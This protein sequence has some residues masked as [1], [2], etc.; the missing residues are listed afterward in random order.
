VSDPEPRIGVPFGDLRREL[1]ECG[2]DLH[3]AAARVIDSG[4]FVLGHELEAFEAEF[5]AYLADDA[6]VV[7]VGS[8]TEAIHLALVDA[9]VGPGDYVITVPNTAVPTVSAISAAGAIPLFADIDPT[10]FTMDPVQLRE[11]VSREKARLGSKLKAVVPVHLYG[12]TAD[13]DSILETAREFELT[14]VEDAAQAAGAQYKGRKAGTIG[15]YG[16]FS[17]YPSKN[18]G[19][20]GDGGAVVVRTAD[21]AARLRMLRNYGQER[22]YHHA[23]KGFN[24]RLDEIQAAILRAKLPRLDAWNRR[25][26]EIAAAYDA[27]ITSAR[28]SKPRAA[29]YG[30]H[31]WHLYVVR[32][33]DR[34]GLMAHL[35]VRGVG[36]L[37]HYPIPVHLQSAY[38][39]LGLERGAFPVAESAAS[40]ILSL[41]MFPQL[42]DEDVAYVSRCVSEYAG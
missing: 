19:C 18:L 14:V 9:G 26:C 28:I 5:A 33:P 24:S 15:D 34:D 4:W 20:Y 23:I 1:R 38:S 32:H 31:A 35:A 16:A 3:D 13:M 2:I 6:H 10:T 17:F 12:Q 36:T 21:E 37:I 42:S 8:G 22:R 30:L 25:R 40:E 39:D 7:G 29:S 27:S 11:V 41:P